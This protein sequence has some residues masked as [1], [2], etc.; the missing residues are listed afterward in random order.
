[1]K[2]IN[3]QVYRDK[4][5]FDFALIYT[6]KDKWCMLHL[7][8]HVDDTLTAP[9]F[10]SDENGNF[11]FTKKELINKFGAKKWELQKGRKLVILQGWI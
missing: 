4:R 6:L 8:Q 2:L 5:G 1:M 7:C 10:Q 3:G 9:M 11:V